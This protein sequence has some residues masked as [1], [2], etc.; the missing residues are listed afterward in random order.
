MTFSE[1]GRSRL[2]DPIELAQAA[3]AVVVVLATC[4]SAVQGS[5]IKPE[6]MLLAS[7]VLGFYF[8]KSV[9]SGAVPRGT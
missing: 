8:G 4:Y 6:M 9:Q 2:T 5:E 1:Q 3:I 7:T